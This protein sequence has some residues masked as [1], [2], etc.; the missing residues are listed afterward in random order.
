MVK[1]PGNFHWIVDQ[2]LQF[3]GNLVC[4]T[5]AVLSPFHID[6]RVC[7]ERSKR[8]FAL[9]FIQCLCQT[10]MLRIS[11]GLTWVLTLVARLHG[12]ADF[13]SRHIASTP[14]VCIRLWRS[15]CVHGKL[16]WTLTHPPPQTLAWHGMCVC[17][18]LTWTLTPPPTLNAGVT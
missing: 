12:M 11:F 14:P 5:R 4:Q 15:R 13:D 17:G 16:T 1:F 7:K 3:T 2:P 18:K 10:L 6:R 8:C 9:E